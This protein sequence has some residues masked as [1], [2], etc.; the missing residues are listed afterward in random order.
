M[1][2]SFV[3]VNPGKVRC[4]IE[5]FRESIIMFIRLFP[6][7]SAFMKLKR[8]VTL[9]MLSLSSAAFAESSPAAE[10]LKDD[11][12]NSE[13]P[14]PG[15]TLSLPDMANTLERW[16]ASYFGK[17]WQQASTERM[18]ALMGM[19]LAQPLAMLNMTD[20][21]SA[22]SALD[23]AEI[24]LLPGRR[25][26]MATFQLRGE[27]LIPPVQGLLGPMG[28]HATVNDGVMRFYPK[29]NAPALPIADASEDLVLKWTAEAL[30]GLIPNRQQMARGAEGI[31]KEFLPDGQFGLTLSPEGLRTRVELQDSAAAF[32]KLDASSLQWL[33]ASSSIIMALNVDLKAYWDQRASALLA[34]AQENNP[35]T[36]DSPEAVLAIANQALA[37]Q[38]ILITADEL[39]AA[40]QGTITIALS[41]NGVLLPGIQIG[42][43]RNP[44]RDKLLEWALKKSGHGV[45]NDDALNLLTLRGI[46]QEIPIIPTNI[47]LVRTQNHWIISTDSI[48]LGDM[49]SGREGKWID[50]PEATLVLE[51]IN[52]DT[53]GIGWGDTRAVLR[54]FTPL[55]SAAAIGLSKEMPPFAMIGEDLQWLGHHLASNATTDY[56]V[57]TRDGNNII[58]EGNGPL[59]GLT[60]GGGPSLS[61]TAML[62][63]LLLPTPAKKHKVAPA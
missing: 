8:F 63:G 35:N 6:E 15:V 48:L 18:E 2:G 22:L 20:L 31:I 23:G 9:T 29:G 24:G 10:P 16:D 37:A 49:I 59:G 3:N 28:S 27:K 47:G 4:G 52:S 44:A 7:E 17:T 5:T 12:H 50:T 34:L 62:A 40:S 39:L 55:L 1:N 54:M 30:I 36:P 14:I 26:P 19:G 51:K 46:Q 11:G 13:V 43:D 56:M 41:G 25:E 57:M 45:I 21:R 42:L 61:T 53:S 58:M 38:G 60:V 32:G 33:P